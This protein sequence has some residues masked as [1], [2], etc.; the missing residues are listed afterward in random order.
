MRFRAP[1]SNP[2]M[3]PTSAGDVG[4]RLRPSLPVATKDHRCSQGRLRLISTSLGGRRMRGGVM[5]A[6]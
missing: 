6:A 5:E 1:Q 2:L 4:R 3:Q